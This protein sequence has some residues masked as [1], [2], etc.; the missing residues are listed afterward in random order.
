M[1]IVLS[2]GTWRWHRVL[3]V[4]QDKTVVVSVDTNVERMALEHNSWRFRLAPSIFFGGA[5]RVFEVLEHRPECCGNT[6][7]NKTNGNNNNT[8]NNNN[9]SAPFRSSPNWA[10]ST[11]ACFALTFVFNP[12]IFTIEGKNNNNSS[13][14]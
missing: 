9:S 4:Y 1:S 6:G 14:L 7:R 3:V 12:G 8:N 10:S 2:V 13:I 5:R 11:P